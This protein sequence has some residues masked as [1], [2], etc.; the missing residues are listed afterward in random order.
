MNLPKSEY[1]YEKISLLRLV[2]NNLQLS[3]Q[4]VYKCKMIIVYY[5]SS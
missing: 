1:D 3:M 5:E 2:L 4:N